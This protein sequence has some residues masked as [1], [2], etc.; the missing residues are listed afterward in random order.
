MQKR[1]NSKWPRLANTKNPQVLLDLPN[2]AAIT[3]LLANLIER[4]TITW[5]EVGKEEFAGG[6]VDADDVIS[7]AAVEGQAVEALG[8]LGVGHLDTADENDLA[9]LAA[10]NQ[11]LEKDIVQRKI[12]AIEFLEPRVQHGGIIGL[13]CGAGF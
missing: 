2:T 3:N 10:V 4:G 9:G 1:P 6:E 5:E 7:T 11:C 12:F 8:F 13:G